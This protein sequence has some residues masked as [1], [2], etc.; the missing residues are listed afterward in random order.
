[1]VGLLDI[2]PSS[3]KVKIDDD[4]NVDVVGLSSGEIAD[5]LIRFPDLFKLMS[6]AGIGADALR[7]VAPEAIAAIIASCTGDHGNTKAEIAAKKL[8]LGAQFNILKAMGRRTFPDGFGPFVQALNDL[9]GDVQAL[10]TKAPATTSPKPPLP[11]E[12]QEIPPSGT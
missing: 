2:R 8:P 4:Q 10:A 9:S 3:E 11:S 6:G 1:M 5:L 12:Q 7:K